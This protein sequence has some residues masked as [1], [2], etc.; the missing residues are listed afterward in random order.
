V[1]IAGKTVGWGKNN[2]HSKS[3][4]LIINR[5]GGKERGDARVNNKGGCR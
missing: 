1:L 4:L 3:V 5:M 2:L